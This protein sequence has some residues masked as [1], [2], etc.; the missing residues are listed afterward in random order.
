M[1]NPEVACCVSY[2]CFAPI[3]VAGS[4]HPN[5]LWAVCPYQKTPC[6]SGA[7]ETG[8]CVHAWKTLHRSGVKSSNDV[9][10][11][12]RDRLK[13]Q[14]QL[15]KMG[16]VPN[17][18][19]TVNWENVARVYDHSFKAWWITILVGNCIIFFWWII[20]RPFLNFFCS[21]VDPTEYAALN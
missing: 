16:A 4:V 8:G 20:R 19:I 17:K 3:V 1:P 15:W 12:L 13:E 2:S 18:F 21:S 5:F 11:M 10:Y 6:A 14:V 7:Q 9:E